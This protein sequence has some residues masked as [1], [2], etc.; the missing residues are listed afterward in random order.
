L[1]DYLLSPLDTT[2]KKSNV[3]IST[4]QLKNMSLISDPL[5]CSM[6]LIFE[7]KR[8]KEIEGREGREGRERERGQSITTKKF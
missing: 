7:G 1:E 4:F 5:K 2:G 6:G 3:F 8:E